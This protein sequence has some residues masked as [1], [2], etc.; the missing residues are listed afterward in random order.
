MFETE[1]G[2]LN[3]CLISPDYVRDPDWDW[4]SV[5]EVEPAR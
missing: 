4:G 5:V 3:R 2:H 1:P